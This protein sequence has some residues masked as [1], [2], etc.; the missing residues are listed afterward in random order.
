MAQGN[1]TPHSRL[2]W[3]VRAGVGRAVTGIAFGAMLLVMGGSAFYC[4]L[5][6]QDATDGQPT[7][8][9]LLFLPLAAMLI[10]GSVVVVVLQSVHAVSRLNGP[11][12]KLVQAMRRMRRGGLP[13]RIQLRRGDLLA[14]LARECNELLEWLGRQHCDEGEPAGDVVRLDRRIRRATA[15]GAVAPEATP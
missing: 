5:L 2:G 7:D 11:E 8:E 9:L 3:F 14:P 12:Q 4:H 6:L 13:E 1:N 10:V 15:A